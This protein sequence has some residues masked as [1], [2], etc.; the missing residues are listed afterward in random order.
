MILHRFAVW[1][2]KT[3]EKLSKS[4]NTRVVTT[5]NQGRETSEP[6]RFLKGLSQG[7]DFCPRLFTVCLNPIGW[8]ISATEGYKLS[9]PISVKVIDLLYTDDL[10]IFVSSESKLNGVMQPAKTKTR[11]RM[12][13]FSGTPK[14]V[15]SFMYKAGYRPIPMMP[16]GNRPIS[17]GSWVSWRR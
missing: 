13:D 12:S 8:K 6:I 16:R 9:K 3:V 4:W 5:T 15:R 7:E 1:L 14:S 10:K 2:S 17:T 11:W